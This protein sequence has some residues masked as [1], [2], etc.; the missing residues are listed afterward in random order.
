M[1]VQFASGEH[2][3]PSPWWNI[4]YN[5]KADQKVDLLEPLPENLQ[6]IQWAYIGHFLEH[7]TPDEGVDF[8]VRVRERMIPGGTIVI[9]GPD[10]VK[11]QRWYDQGRIPRF[12]L[13]AIK[14]HGEPIGN[15]RGNCH[16]WDCTGEAVVQQLL[17]AGFTDA[18]EFP[19]GELPRRFS[20]IPV[21]SLD[22]WQFA[23]SA[24]A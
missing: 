3:F 13:D 9:V 8:L 21:I 10:A 18:E 14:A 22:E 20:K 17:D 19:L 23:A 1:R 15:N 16:M 5:T 7:L 12:L 4:D 24:K 2:C 6:E 11:G